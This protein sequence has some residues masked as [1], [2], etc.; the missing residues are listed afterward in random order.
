MRQSIE[1]PHLY[2][3]W[4]GMKARCNNPNRPR[5]RNYGGRGIK[6]CAEWSNSSE[7][8][9]E[10][11]LAHGYRDGLQID[12]INVNGGY[13]PDNCRWVTA[14]ENARN[15]RDNVRLIVDGISKTASEWAEIAGVSRF[16]VY[17]WVKEKGGEYAAERLKGEVYG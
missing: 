5:Y 2:S 7:A 14:K 1:Y 15:R 8:F 4:R 12:R 13:N 10:W 11:A 9:I 3:I 17:W 6:V 16:T